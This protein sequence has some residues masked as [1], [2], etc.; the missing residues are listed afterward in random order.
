MAG[1]VGLLYNA[2]ADQPCN[3]ATELVGPA[4]PGA[5]WLFQWCTQ[6]VAQEL[7]YFPATGNKD[8]FWDQGEEA[9]MLQTICMALLAM[10]L[11]L[12]IPNPE[13]SSS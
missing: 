1:A 3:N 9:F 12:F 8:M 4:G 2:S 10:S 13:S 5:T 6:R 11:F 7:P